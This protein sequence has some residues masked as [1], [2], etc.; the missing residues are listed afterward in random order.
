MG[1]IKHSQFLENSLGGL[2]I[3]IDRNI[4]IAFIKID[5]KNKII[6]HGFVELD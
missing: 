6:L 1:L 3:L 5:D 4:F 2:P